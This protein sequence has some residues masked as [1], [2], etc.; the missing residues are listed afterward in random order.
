MLSSWRCTTFLWRVYTLCSLGDYWS[1]SGVRIKSSPC[2]FTALELAIWSRAGI[3]SAKQNLSPELISRAL[4]PLCC[5]FIF[6]FWFDWAKERG[7]A[8]VPGLDCP[9]SF[10][11]AKQ[12]AEPNHLLPRTPF[13]SFVQSSTSERS[14]R[15]GG[16]VS[17]QLRPF[18]R[19]NLFRS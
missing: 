2:N 1:P 3:R 13:F 8:E 5:I 18:F 14:S 4:R 12:A 15:A 19:T 11:Q 6:I 9:C 17:P 7:G 10:F 16:E